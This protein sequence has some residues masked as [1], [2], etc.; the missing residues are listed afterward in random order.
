MAKDMNF[1]PE[2]YLE[3]RA[4]RRTNVFCLGLFALMLMG[5]GGGYY[6][7]AQQDESVR[8][9]QQA[10]NVRFEEAA[11]RI[12][13]LQELQSRKATMMRKARITSVLVERVPRSLILSQLINH[14]PQTLSL[15][16]TEMKT[17]VVQQARRPRTSLQA[18]QQRLAK[19]EAQ[20][21]GQPP[22]VEL[23]ETRVTM[24]LEGLAPTDLEV[25]QFIG[26]LSGHEMFHDVNLIYSREP[27]RSPYGEK[28]N[29]RQVR[30]F[31]LELAVTQELDLQHLEPTR[32]A[33]G[34]E[35]NPMS[36]QVTITPPKPD[37]SKAKE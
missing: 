10:V 16:S 33:R 9:T 30:E 32:V 25:S 23:P 35:Q 17:E 2:D 31:R 15:T 22:P 7:Y 8:E 20:K 34:L 4:A 1:L 12:E 28:S 37:A 29:D 11:Q 21:E 24:V 13:Q 6:V 5:V 36:D 26:A 27:G 3:K 18:E 14:M 19:Q